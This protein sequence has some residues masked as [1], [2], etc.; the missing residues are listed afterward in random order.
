VNSDERHNGKK[1]GHRIKLRLYIAGDNP[2]SEKT[3]NT[4]TA[5]CTQHLKDQ[6]SIEV[7][8]I[9]QNP[10]SAEEDRILAIP[11]LVRYEP[12]PVRKI[13]GDLSRVESVLMALG[14]EGQ[15]GA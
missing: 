10:R 2:R 3:R 15:V 8:D 5:I 9:L 7:I 12:S 4:I 14:I 11:T 13:I 1:N 6:C